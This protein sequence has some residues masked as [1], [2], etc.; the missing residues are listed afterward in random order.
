MADAISVPLEP[1]PWLDT[2]WTVSSHRQTHGPLSPRPL[3]FPPPLRAGP[4][5]TDFRE[6][7]DAD[8]GR[9]VGGAHVQAL[10][11]GV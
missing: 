5:R 1:S 2:E 8:A 4:F 7:L 10:D 9:Q 3:E 6:L 11:G